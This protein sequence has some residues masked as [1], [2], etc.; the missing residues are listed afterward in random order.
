M[1]HRSRLRKQGQEPMNCPWPSE[2]GDGG[3]TTS[4]SNRFAVTRRTLGHTKLN[5]H[6]SLKLRFMFFVSVIA[7]NFFSLFTSPWSSNQLQQFEVVINRRPRLWFNC[8]TGTPLEWEWRRMKVR[9]KPPTLPGRRQAQQTIC[10]F[11]VHQLTVND[12]KSSTWF[13]Q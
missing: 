7:P 9:Q 10:T 1:E 8:W 11:Q 13:I 3:F 5:R 2:W 12:I 4:D 6:V